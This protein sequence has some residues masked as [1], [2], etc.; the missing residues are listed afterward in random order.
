MLA[1]A[2]ATHVRMELL[3]DALAERDALIL[4]KTMMAEEMQHRVRNNLQL[5]HAMLEREASEPDKSR[6]SENVSAIGRRIMTMSR[7][8]DHLLGT[9][10]ARTI[11]FGAYL[12]SLCHALPEMQ[13]VDDSGG[14]TVRC[15]WESV[16]LG[17]D[18]VTSLGLV[19]AELVANSYRH[20]FPDGRGSITITLRHGRNGGMSTL[21]I[22]DDGVGLPHVASSNRRGLGLVTRLMQQVRGTIAQGDGPG[23]TWLLTFPPLVAAAAA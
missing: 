11:D 18:S 21:S 15:D 8:Y 22:S 7:V 1:E 9:G 12:D 14:I 6:L 16:K 3:R 2:V 4:E 23:T 10:M 19:V 17:L 5:V 13:H 20:A